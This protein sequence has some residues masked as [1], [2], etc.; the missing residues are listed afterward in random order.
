MNEW[1]VTEVEE[2]VAGD[3]VGG[4]SRDRGIGGSSVFVL[5]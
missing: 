2:G 3:V 1:Q 4:L 5:I